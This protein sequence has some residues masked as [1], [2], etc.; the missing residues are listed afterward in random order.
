MV[1]QPNKDR[2]TTPPGVMDKPDINEFL[3]KYGSLWYLYEYD[4]AMQ[5]YKNQ[6]NPG[7]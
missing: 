7:G 2:T 1:H 6:S 4:L 5:E 3:E